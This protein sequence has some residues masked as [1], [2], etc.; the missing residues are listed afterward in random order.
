MYSFNNHCSKAF[1]VLCGHDPDFEKFRISHA[2]W[3]E[4][5]QL[6]SFFKPFVEATLKMSG[7]KYPTLSGVIV[8]FNVIMDHLDEYK[9]EKSH[10]PAKIKEAANA[11]YVKIV[12]FYNKTNTTNCMVT[13]LDPRWNV[14]FFD[15]NGFSK[16]QKASFLKR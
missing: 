12:E 5:H 7:Q 4:I 2:E 6:L 1:N 16:A 15:F 13:L 11:A 3:H 8:L 14:Q 10:I 9:D